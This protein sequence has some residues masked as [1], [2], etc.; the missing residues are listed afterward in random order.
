MLP[1][2]RTP[3]PLFAL[4]L[5]IGGGA[6]STSW[7]APPSGCGITPNS[8]YVGRYFCAQGWTDMTLSVVDVEGPRVRMQGTFRH[9]GTGVQGAYLLR[10]FCFP[11]SRRMVLS[12]QAWVQQPPGYIMVGMS[13]LVSGEGQ[14]FTGR[15][16]HRSC[17]AFTF[18]RQ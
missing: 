5:C 4:T 12:P 14:A 11:T 15:M 8:T 6:A 13:G 18:T 10:G 7:A 9:A 1:R 17:G 16:L 2:M 3:L